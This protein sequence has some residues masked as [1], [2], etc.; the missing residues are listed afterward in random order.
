M[1]VGAT[2]R[3]LRVGAGVG[4]RDLAQRVGVSSAYLSRVENGHDPCPTP[5]RLEAIARELGLAPALLLDVTGRLAPFLSAY[6]ES[7]PSA[8]SLFSEIARRRLDAEDLAKVLRYVRR[9]FPLAPD[10]SLGE[11]SPLSELLAT[12]RVVLDVS[13]RR[14]EDVLDI[15]AAKLAGGRREIAPILAAALRQREEASSSAIGGGLWVPQALTRDGDAKVAVLTLAQ[16]L[17]VAAPDEEPVQVIVALQS[18]ERGWSHLARLAQIARL[19]RHGLV[20][21]LLAARAPAQVIAAIHQLE[22]SL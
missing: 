19:A 11:L 17:R 14:A 12:D 13:V 8:S 18:R 7:V 4:L 20:A 2:L 22:A 16:P 5:D 1:H 3:L 9:E 15:V 21:R 6:V 10:R